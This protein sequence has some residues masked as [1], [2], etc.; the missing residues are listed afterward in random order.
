M[1]GSTSRPAL[2]MLSGAMAFTVMGA[3]TH[4]LGPRCD[5]LIVALVRTLFMFL[6]SA[7]MAIALGVR[8]SAFD[9]PRLWV[10]SLAG[11]VSLLCNFFALARLPM[12]DAVTLSNLYPLWIVLTSS[13]VL[14]RPPT[15]AEAV[16]LLCALAGVVVIER[17]DLDV[18]RWAALAALGSS[19]STAVA[20]FG[21]HRLRNVDSRAVVAHFGAVGA[22]V[23]GVSSCFR[24]ASSWYGLFVPG[25][26]ALLLGV[27]VA[28]TIGQVF[29]TKAY[30]AGV[31]ARI[32]VIS[33]SQVAFAMGLDIWLWGRDLDA[34]TLAGFALVLGPTAW[35]TARGGAKHWLRTQEATAG[36]VTLD[37]SPAF[38]SEEN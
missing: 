28:G 29:L 11:T 33:L 17:P 2:W 26:A 27:G 14:R 24:P 16:G 9:P 37:A 36:P 3:F 38:F 23:V 21:L 19:V 35:L 25:T 5:W 1:S 18:D 10:R 12:A 22:L 4:A 15:L 20:M 8:L 13:I 31:P 32:S 34:V 30:A 6:T 7:G